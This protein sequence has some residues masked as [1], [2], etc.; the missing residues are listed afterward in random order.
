[1]K[2][3]N[4]DGSIKPHEYFV[5]N[6]KMLQVICTESTEH[7]NTPFYNHSV[8]MAKDFIKNLETGKITEVSR[9]KLFELKIELLK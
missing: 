3:V 6:K 1:M 8:W 7:P 2:L 5:Y 9:K 4:K